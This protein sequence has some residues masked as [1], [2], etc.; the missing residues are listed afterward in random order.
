MNGLNPNAKGDLPLENDVVSVSSVKG[1]SNSKFWRPTSLQR[2]DKRLK[3]D[4]DLGG[5]E[6]Q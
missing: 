1:T 6:V 2:D 4:L 3:L 5:A